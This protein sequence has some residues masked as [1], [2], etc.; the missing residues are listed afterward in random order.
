M[1]TD[2]DP[3][4][5]FRF[6]LMG[7]PPEA[8]LTTAEAQI[9]CRLGKTAWASMRARRETP[10]AMKLNNLMLAYRKHVLDEWLE[11]RMEVAA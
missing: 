3:D 11:K 2:T 10:V 6:E 9:Y 7:W 1:A 5:A 8:I 4:R